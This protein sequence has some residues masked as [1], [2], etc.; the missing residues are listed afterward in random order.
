LSCRRSPDG[1]AN[2]RARALLI[3]ALKSD[4]IVLGLVVN[5]L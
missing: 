3:V 2:P 4:S 5:D 1:L